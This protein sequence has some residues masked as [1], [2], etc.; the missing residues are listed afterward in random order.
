MPG[1][2]LAGRNL[3]HYGS[4]ATTASSLLWGVG[5]TITSAMSSSMWS[6]A[7]NINLATQWYNGPDDITTYIYSSY[8]PGGSALSQL[9]DLWNAGKAVELIVYLLSGSDGRPS[10]SGTNSLTTTTPGDSC[11]DYALTSQC[12]TDIANL[13]SWFSVDSG[14]TKHP[15]FVSLFTEF[16]TYGYTTT[17]YTTL[18]GQVPT[19]VA[20]CHAVNPLAKVG[21]GFAGYDYTGGAG[22]NF[23]SWQ[24]AVE[25]S[26]C[27]FM[28]NMQS[29]A[30][31]DA[32]G[33][34]LLYDAAVN[35]AQTM[36]NSGLAKPWGVDHAQIWAGGGE[37]YANQALDA[38]A[39][40]TSEEISVTFQ[41]FDVWPALPFYMS[42]YNA[43]SGGTSTT[44]QSTVEVVEVTAA[45]LVSGTALTAGAVYTFTCTRGANGIVQ[46]M[47]TNSNWSWCMNINC[48]GSF[49]VD[50]HYN[51]N[52]AGMCLNLQNQMLCNTAELEALKA[53]GLFSW[54]FMLGTTGGQAGVMA[55][56][57]FLWPGAEFSPLAAFVN[58]HA[59]PSTAG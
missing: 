46:A 6:S 37:V 38:P 56:S 47:A 26:D 36:T 18:A 33:R 41:D 40:G 45:T 52:P 15:I 28:Q 24:S 34:S 39:V 54:S 29:A 7:P 21:L 3:R 58:T 35:F 1:I 8:G 4:T 43:S 32:Q 50:Q 10:G 23:G 57:W 55:G 48:V 25:A 13:V 17:Q 12:V 53:S 31:Y 19:I 51:A 2:H 27:V 5:D 11:P 14:G 20:A 49:V 16:D 42:V 30:S 22:S 44:P 59:L 9:T